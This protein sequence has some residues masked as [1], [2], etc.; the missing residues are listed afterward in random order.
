MRLLAQK[1]LHSPT[2]SLCAMTLA[3]LPLPETAGAVSSHKHW[4]TT[5]AIH[6]ANARLRAPSVRPSS[7]CAQLSPSSP[8]WTCDQ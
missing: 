1:D 7:T 6:A 8:Y 2:G 4:S 5:R 3:P